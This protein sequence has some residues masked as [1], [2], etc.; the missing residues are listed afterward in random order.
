MAIRIAINGF[1]RIGRNVLRIASKRDDIEIVHINDLTS[2]EMLAYLLRRDT[3]HGTFGEEI[4]GVDGGISIDGHFIPTSSERDPAKLPWAER[5]IDVV[6]ECTGAFTTGESAGQ[7]RTAGARKV[8]ISAPAT[9][10]HG[11]FV[12][13]VNDHEYDP[14]N[15]HVISNASCTTN[16]LAPVVS[17]LQ[18]AVGIQHGVMTTVHSYTMNQ[19]LLDGPHRKGKFRRA[20]AAAQN[21]V[22]TT[23]GAAKAIALVMPELADK[24]H[25]IAIRVPTPNVSLIDLVFT[26]GRNTTTE[27]I[28][29]ALTEAAQGHL[30]GVLQ[31]TDEPLVSSDLVGNSNSSIIDLPLTHVMDGNLVKVLSWY[32]N[33]WGFSNRMLDLAARVGAQ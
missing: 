19:N 21:M 25:G 13:G 5:K 33:E 11:T 22:P 3:V 8:I 9:Q 27:E 31:V 1:G 24:L 6:L 15:H 12:V 4:K 14:E 26:A 30:K 2:D 16:C 10:V 29:G 18:K 20:R 23:T 7:H 28:N 17:V 32:D